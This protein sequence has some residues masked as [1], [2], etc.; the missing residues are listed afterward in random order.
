MPGALKKTAFSAAAS[1]LHM[2][3][4]IITSLLL[5]KLATSWL[6]NEV[7]GLWN[8]LF[9]TVS[10]F[11][12]LEFGFGQGV[13][14]LLGEPLARGD[15]GKASQLVSTGLGLLIIQSLVVTAVGV[16]LGNFF[17]DW[18][19]V[20]ARLREKAL[21]LWWVI[22]LARGLSLP[23]V[24]LHGVIWAQ[25]RVYIIY[26]TGLIASWVGLGVFYL[27][28]THGAD[29]L[30]YAWSVGVPAVLTAVVLVAS[31][32][33]NSEGIRVGFSHFKWPVAK[34]IVGFSSAVFV[35]T[36]VPQLST[37][38]LS[39]IAARVCGLEAT[40][41]L[42]VN[43]R[44]AQLLSSIATR[45]FDA[46]IPRWA[47]TYCNLGIG[48]VR[49]EYLIVSRLT[50]LTAVSAGIV[51]LLCNRPFIEWWTRPDLF[52]GNLLTVVVVA[53]MLF[54][55]FLRLMSFPFM[56]ARELRMLAG[57]LIGGL[58]IE[59]ALQWAF[60]SWF[61][62]PGLVAA[63]PLAGMLLVFWFAGRGFSRIMEVNWIRLLSS[64]WLWL[65]PSVIAAVLIPIWWVP[66]GDPFMR[67]VSS[68]LVAMALLVPIGVRV[69][70]LCRTMMAAQREGRSPGGP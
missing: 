20:P 59:L 38:S 66:P 63:V 21:I 16:S 2:G 4:S 28:L 10:Y 48:A 24:I 17:L 31:L 34:E 7:L 36:L 69:S 13:A 46:F 19:G 39:F 50:F 37:V 51:I 15:Q 26:F 62:L 23:L 27:G 52:G 25:N 33:R 40:A 43:T 61:G 49:T 68:G 70:Q 65:L 64:D 45:A 57:V 6:S 42:A 29:L 56:L 53:A 11:A 32:I 54:Q 18:A 44:I 8:F 35:T 47:A 5:L 9:A 3:S 1:Y 14:R 12:L 41:V 67:L 22:V 58:L 60:A 30:A 55:C